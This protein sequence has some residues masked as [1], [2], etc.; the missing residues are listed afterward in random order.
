MRDRC[1]ECGAPVARMTAKEFLD[2]RPVPK[3]NAFGQLVECLFCNERLVRPRVGRPPITCKKRPCK[4]ALLRLRGVKRDL[5]R[6]A[7]V[8]R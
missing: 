4:L 3:M 5:E 7:G 1:K 8:A 2:S 6:M